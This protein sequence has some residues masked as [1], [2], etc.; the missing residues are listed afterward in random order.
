MSLH[1]KTDLEEKIRYSLIKCFTE[2]VLPDT[3]PAILVDLS[4][5]NV[6]MMCFVELKDSALCEEASRALETVLRVANKP[7]Q[8]EHLYQVFHTNIVNS[9]QF[10]K[11]LADDCATEEVQGFL[12]V[13]QRFF[14]VILPRAVKMPSEPSIEGMCEIF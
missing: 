11:D 14:L 6:L 4:Q 9:F 7:D 12:K 10:C 13:Y 8:Y 5:H 1:E 3:D 2:W